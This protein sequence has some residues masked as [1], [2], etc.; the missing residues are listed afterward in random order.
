MN[1]IPLWGIECLREGFILHNGYDIYLGEDV[2]GKACVKQEGLYYHFQCWCRLPSAS[3]H[4][5]ILQSRG[6]EYNLGVCVPDGD[7][8]R[9][10][11]RIPIKQFDDPEF[12]FYLMER[13]Q[14]NKILIAVDSQKPFEHLQDLEN[15]QLDLSNE[16]PQICLHDSKSLNP[17]QQGNDQSREQQSQ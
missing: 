15:A 7:K 4:C 1:R 6:K 10:D 8:F 11:K 5:V 3:I 12:K 2:T 13:N 16:L 14:R 9:A 17:V